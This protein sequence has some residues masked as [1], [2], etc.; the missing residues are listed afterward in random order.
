MESNKTQHIDD[1]NEKNQ[2]TNTTGTG[3][4]INIIKRRDLKISRSYLSGFFY[5]GFRR[6]K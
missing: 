6:M 1:R 5:W 2:P 3:F 4:K